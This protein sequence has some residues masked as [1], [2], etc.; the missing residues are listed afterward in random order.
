MVG[1]DNWSGLR[2]FVITFLALLEMVH[3]ALVR[4]YQPDPYKEI[5]LEIMKKDNGD[6]NN[7]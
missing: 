3:M 6:L 2:E 7:E 1:I 5:R 4:I